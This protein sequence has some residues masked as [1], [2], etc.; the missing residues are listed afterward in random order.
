MKIVRQASSV[1]TFT[2]AYEGTSEEVEEGLLWAPENILGLVL[3]VCAFL[4]WMVSLQHI[5]LSHMNDLGLVSVFTPLT[6]V[7]LSMLSVSFC[8]LITRP[9]TRVQVLLLHLLLL[10][11]M[12]YGVAALVEEMPRF[13]VVYRHTGFTEYI[14]RNGTVDPNLDAY[15]NWPGFFILSALFTRLAGYR[16]ALAFAAW[17]PVLYNLL[18]LGPLY[19]IFNVATRDRRLLWLSLWFFY[20]MNWIGQDYFSPQGLNLFMYLVIIAILLQ[21]FQVPR[22]TG[23][24]GRLSCYWQRLWSFSQLTRKMYIWFAHRPEGIHSPGKQH[25]GL[26]F[27]LLLIFA[28]VDFSHPLTPFFVLLS[29]LALCLF[30]RAWPFWLPLVFGVMMAAWIYFM[31][32]AYLAGHFS[33]AF[34][35]GGVVLG[36]TSNVTQRV[37][38]DQQHIFIAQIRLAMTL[39]LWILAGIGCLRRFL[40]G[41]RDLSYILLALAPFPLFVAQ[42]YGGEMLLRIY[43]FVLPMMVFFAASNVFLK[44]SPNLSTSTLRTIVTATVCLLLLSS[45]LFTR[46]GNE[47]MD[48]MTVN[49]VEGV[50]HL[51]SIAP[52]DSVL[53]AGWAG[54]PW[55][56]QQYEKY[57]TYNL[58]DDLPGVVKDVDTTAIIHFLDTQSTANRHHR[59]AYMIFTHSERVTVDATTGLPPGALDRL[60]EALLTTGKFQRVYSNPDADILAYHPAL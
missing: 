53:V 13:S 2:A 18:Y 19:M 50:R 45:F 35:S 15:F 10:I 51:Y 12:L 29:V 36:V 16:D 42:S 46:Y 20:L 41:Y 7:A 32:Q 47:N 8:W 22:A 56:F 30:R 33:A 3:P 25:V 11:F 9:D 14:T 52:V 57:Q 34:G 38:G 54:T 26:L 44:P 4:L 60:E 58:T 28:F 23:P 24:R 43:L 49:E 1:N 21:W 55:E 40:A 37:I 5:D 59:A 31:T 27:C 39:L 48:H 17:V 6:I